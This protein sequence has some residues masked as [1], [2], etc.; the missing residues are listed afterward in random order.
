MKLLF[1]HPGSLALLGLVVL[2]LL[3]HLFSRA[4]PHELPFSSVEFLR[5]IQRR[6]TRIKK[7]KERLLLLLRTCALLAI[8][9]AF[10]LPFLIGDHIKPNSNGTTVVVL[11]DRSASMAAKEGAASRYDAAAVLAE[12]YLRDAAPQ[13][14]N[15]IWIDAEPNAIFPSPAANLE[16]LIAEIKKGAPLPEAEDLPTSFEIALRQLAEAQG[17]K[18]LLVLSD[19]ASSSW[20]NFA[21]SIPSDVRLTLQRVAVDAPPNIAITSLTVSQTS[22]VIGQDISLLGRVKNFS[23]EAVR[24]RLTLEA[25]GARQSQDLN[26]A[27][28]G[29]TECAFSIKPTR[30]GW[31]GVTATLDADAF[32]FDNSRCAAIR[33][34]ENLLMRMELPADS[35]EFT[36]MRKAASALGWLS[37]IDQSSPQRTVDFLYLPNATGAELQAIENLTIGSPSIIVR[38]SPNCSLV[39]LANYLLIEQEQNGLCSLDASST[40]WKLIPSENHPANALFKSGDYGN[41]FAGLFRER[42]KIPPPWAA[43]RRARTLATYVDGIPAAISF[44][45]NSSTVLL[46]NLSFDPAKSNWATQSPFLPAIGEILLHHAPNRGNQHLPKP[47]GFALAFQSSDIS[48][49]GSMNL[50]DGAGNP[51]AI[52]EK[53]S[54]IGCQF[55]TQNPVTPGLYRWQNAGQ[56]IHLDAVHFP[57][58]ESDLRILKDDPSIGTISSSPES[59][60][61]Q[62]ALG[63]GMPIWHWLAIAAVI[64]LALE[65]LLHLRSTP[66]ATA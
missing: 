59:L 11:L 28:W 50:E 55:L 17:A 39:D 12:K 35:A 61:R 4:R 19:F 3:V 9:A 34:R 48:L 37:I 52:A 64:F 33:V 62:A 57:E 1:Q 46:W 51:V 44:E 22:P 18:E 53:T 63:K 2:P 58:S 60:A 16:H 54:A 29:E 25:G 47:S 13:N 66:L 56:D 41:P 31:L 45:K 27:P 42:V 20:K 10:A 5:M 49:S 8:A 30:P 24:T 7:P 43:H 32:A 40:G 36:L 14:A 23:A 26:I 38:P 6:S 65:S 21:P 15:L